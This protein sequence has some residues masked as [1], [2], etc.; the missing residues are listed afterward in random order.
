MIFK[1]GERMGQAL[2]PFRSIAK[3]LGVIAELYELELAART[4]AKGQPAPIRRVTEAPG[5][6]D[7]E[8]LWT[9]VDE[10]KVKVDIF[11]DAGEDDL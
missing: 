10:R 4:D 2:H 11:V 6:G 3:S 8:V 5:R 7:T 9:G 1:L